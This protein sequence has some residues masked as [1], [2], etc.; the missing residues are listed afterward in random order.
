MIMT[1]T[2]TT[3]A[4]NWVDDLA[5]FTLYA[6]GSF[7]FQEEFYKILH[8]NVADE[9]NDGGKYD[10]FT[11]KWVN[12]TY[13]EYSAFKFNDTKYWVSTAPN[14]DDFSRGAKTPQEAIVKI[15]AATT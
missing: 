2:I 1:Q 3:K 9:F 13:G 10:I 4:E 11:S 5:T 6:D 7:V 12:E 8:S 15:L 14:M